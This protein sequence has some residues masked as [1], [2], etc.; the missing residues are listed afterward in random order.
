MYHLRDTSRVKETTISHLAGLRTQRG[1]SAARLAE[2]TG[3]SRQTIYA[4]EAGSYVPN[5]VVALRLARALQVKVENLFTLAGDAPAAE[6]GTTTATLLSGS[7]TPRAGQPV[8]LCRVDRNLFALAPSAVP[9]FIPAYDAVA[10]GTASRTGKTAVQLFDPDL[11]FGVRILLAGCDPAMSVLARHAGRAGVELTL[12]H[13]NSSVALALLRQGSI[14]IAG[15]HLRDE[16]S[17]ESNL[18]A[19]R[20]LFR[21]GSVTVFSYAVWE[22]GIVTARANPK[23]ITSIEDLARPDIVIVNREAGAGSRRLLDHH[24]AR[25]GIPSRKV[26]GY[27]TEAP[28][29]LAAARQVRS[30]AVD[31]CIATRAAARLFGLDFIPLVTERYDL[32]IRRRYLALRPVQSLLDVLSRSAFR[33]E[34]E[35]L[36][37]YDASTAGR[38][39]L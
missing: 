21:Q 16:A 13:R 33:R 1:I 26:G 29:H 6:T 25:L 3:V 12:A 9:P 23:G 36:G 22:E 27:S 10:A 24:L 11:D 7:E 18:A 5:T 34:L 4:I 2:M 28:G 17:G 38:R 14:H 8:R 20:R 31:C 32:V 35:L 39:M 19:V 37:G 30:G 15:T